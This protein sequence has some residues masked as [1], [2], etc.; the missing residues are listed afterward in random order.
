MELNPITERQRYE[1]AKKKVR[2]IRGFYVNLGLYCLIMPVLVYIN[3]NYTPDFY[4]FFFSMAGWGL[5]ILFHGMEAFG[6]N[7]FFG[8]DWEERKLKEILEKERNKTK[9]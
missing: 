4:W 2:S 9:Q 6:W 5:G 1:R 3:L 8:K 7:P